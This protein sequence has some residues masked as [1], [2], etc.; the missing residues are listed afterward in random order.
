MKRLILPLLFLL[1][2]VL[3]AQP[4]Y[5]EGQELTPD[6]LV[7]MKVTQV[8]SIK[9]DAP[10]VRKAVAGYS[11]KGR[12]IPVYYFPGTGTEHAIVIGGVH[13]SERSAIEVA[14]MVISLLSKG[15]R[16]YYHIL[17]I[18]EL[19]PDNSFEAEAALPGKVNAGRYSDA[20]A[21]D[22][23]R[24]MPALGNA[25]DETLPLDALGRP[26]EMENVLLLKMIRD[27]HPTRIVSIHA[28]RDSLRAGIFADPRTACNGLALGFEQDSILAIR[29]ASLANELGG[30]TP[31]NALDS[32]PNAK[33][34]LDPAPVAA[35]CP[36]PRNLQGSALGNKRGAG[37]SLGSWASTA[38]C[39][40]NHPQ[41]N[42]EAIQLITMEF[43]GYLP[44]NSFT[45]DKRN[46]K[47]LQVEAFAMAIT[48]V[49]AR[50]Y[51]AVP[52]FTS[53]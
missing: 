19:F 37:I 21:V 49:F 2:A 36:Q 5:A 24:Q 17:V 45:G 33:Y 32:S 29:M 7:K 1:P 10:A 18:P 25:F 16:P 26:I 9:A 11:K 41:W 31:G 28:I 46:N 15:E 20:C 14:R 51:S 52:A 48:N 27:F 39:D 13:G 47:R 8:A 35:G 34:Y 42:R 50:K 22:P 30:W 4:E 6:G 53:R 3:L 40:P 23:N 43:P 12:S 38:V 44:S